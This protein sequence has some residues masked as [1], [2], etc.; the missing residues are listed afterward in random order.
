MTELA[1][2]KAGKLERVPEGVS[3]RLQWLCYF[4]KPRISMLG[5]GWHARIEMNTNTTGAQF[6]VVSE[7]GMKSPDAALQQLVERMLTAVTA[8][9]G[10]GNG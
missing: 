4:G 8:A 2:L 1:T 10:G 7:F 9:Q 3:E 5:E 6:T